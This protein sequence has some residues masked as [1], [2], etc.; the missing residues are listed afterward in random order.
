M[1]K[2][3]IIAIGDRQTDRQTALSS[4]KAP[5]PTHTHLVGPGGA[6]YD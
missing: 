5:P 4:L 2:P 1:Y 3:H 6:Y